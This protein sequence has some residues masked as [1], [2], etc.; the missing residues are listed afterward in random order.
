MLF[1]YGAVSDFNKNYST[2]L[3]IQTE[4]D[5]EEGKESSNESGSTEEVGGN[6]FYN[7]WNW[8]H[9]VRVVSDLVHSPWDIVFKMNIIEFLNILSYNNDYEQE[10]ERIYKEKFKIK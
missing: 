7:K 6:S 2:L 3:G 10:R 9:Q 1:F 4:E 8:I 5:S